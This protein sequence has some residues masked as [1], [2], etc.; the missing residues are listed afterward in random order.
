MGAPALNIAGQTSLRMVAALLAHLH[1]LIG[2][3]SGL[4]HLAVAVRTPVVVIFGAA[5]IETW[6]HRDQRRYRARSIAVPCR[7]CALSE[8]PIGYKC[9]EGVTV[10]S[11]IAEAE[12]LLH[13][14]WNSFQMAR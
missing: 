10:A 5:Q 3:D 11:V 12:Y 14:E 4:A 2:N 8:C 6:E 7:P 13:N 1:L 9:L